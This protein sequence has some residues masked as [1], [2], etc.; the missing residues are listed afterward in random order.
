MIKLLKVIGGNFH[1]LGLG[2]GFFSITLKAQMTKE[3]T[4]KLDC[5]KIYFFCAENNAIKI[6]KIQS[7]GWEK[8]SANQLCDISLISSIHRTLII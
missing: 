7:T 2:N 8:I 5:I 1:E 6:V 4:D 3:K